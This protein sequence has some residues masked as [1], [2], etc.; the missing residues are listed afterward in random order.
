M[1]KKE[2]ENILQNNFGLTLSNSEVD[3]ESEYFKR[4][5]HLLGERIQ[6]LIRTDMDRLLQI[7]YRIDV[8]QKESDSA[9]DLGDIKK[10]SLNLA[11]KV[12]NRQ[13]QKIDYAKNF[14]GKG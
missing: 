14:Y 10:I 4:L 9:F 13:L 12:I 3:T 11:E 6:F 8:P 2:L 5:Q 7:L 1:S